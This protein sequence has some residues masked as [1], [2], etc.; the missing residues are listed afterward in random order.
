MSAAQSAILC[1]DDE[2]IVTQALRSLLEQNLHEIDVVEVAEMGK[3]ALEVID[4]LVADGI[5]L[6]VVVADY[7]MPQMRGDELLVRIH[8]QL[9]EVKTIM[10]TGQSDVSGVKR[11]INEAALYH[12]IEKPWHNE[13]LLLTLRG[14]LAAYDQERELERQSVQLREFNEELRALNQALERK[15]EERTRELE[16]KNRELERLAVTDWLTGLYNRVKLDAELSVEVARAERYGTSFSIILLDI[17]HFK[18]IND[19]HGHQMGD[20]VLTQLADILRK[21]SRASDKVGRWGGEEFLLIC[22]HT[23]LEGARSLAEHQRALIERHPFETL[24]ECTASYGV[25]QYRSG[26]TAMTLLARVDAALYR[27]KASGRNR[28]EAAVS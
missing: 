8:Q 14:A 6:K 17:D 11:A 9:P 27:A 26:E 28:V 5:E 25:A 24:S 18:R 22:P 4:E 7:I 3:E 2:P 16:E 1:I 12:F 13:D 21:S 20:L 15:V 10:L 23:E 19:C